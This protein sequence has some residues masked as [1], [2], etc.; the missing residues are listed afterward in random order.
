MRLKDSFAH[1]L[2]FFS[3]ALCLINKRNANGRSARVLSPDKLSLSPSCMGARFA[4]EFQTVEP[5][6]EGEFELFKNVYGI[7][8]H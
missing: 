3:Q 7:R 5:T 4:K 2:A 1:S 8:M 6:D